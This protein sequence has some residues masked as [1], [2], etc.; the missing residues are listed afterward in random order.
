VKSA[1][2]LKSGFYRRPRT[3]TIPAMTRIY[4]TPSQIVQAFRVHTRLDRTAHRPILPVCQL[5]VKFPPGEPTAPGRAGAG[6]SLKS[7]ASDQSILAIVDTMS[8][9]VHRQFTAALDELVDKIKLDRS[10]LAAILC[11]SLSHDTG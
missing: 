9:A 7:F 6:P 10:I 1:L 3:K 8:T 4:P 5:K 11:G 2:P